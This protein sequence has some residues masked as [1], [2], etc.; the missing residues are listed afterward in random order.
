M[1]HSFYERYLKKA[2]TRIAGADYLR[3]DFIE[4]LRAAN[5]ERWNVVE[6][7]IQ[8]R[9]EV[10][11]EQHKILLQAKE[12]KRRRY[13]KLLKAVGKIVSYGEPLYLSKVTPEDATGFSAFGGTL[14]LKS[15]ISNNMISP[16]TTQQ[17]NNF[18]SEIVAFQQLLELKKGL[19]NVQTWVDDAP[20]D[21]VPR[22]WEQI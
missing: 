13:A 5:D 21:V 18:K 8:I 22:G 3:N 6:K 4:S 17:F 9:K 12:K 16:F 7:G 1:Y 19:K 10:Q 11:P 14:Y 15:H 20:N 2:Y